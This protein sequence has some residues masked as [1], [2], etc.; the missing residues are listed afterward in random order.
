MLEWKA[1]LE[2][3]SSKRWMHNYLCAFKVISNKVC[4]Y[5]VLTTLTI[6][7]VRPEAEHDEK[8]MPGGIFILTL[9]HVAWLP[10]GVTYSSS[11]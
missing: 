3:L 8:R 9:K 2:I 10:S 5:C 4:G 11:E 7:M 1:T 6:I